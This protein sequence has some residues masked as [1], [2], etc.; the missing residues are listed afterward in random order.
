MNTQDTTLQP[1]DKQGTASKLVAASSVKANLRGALDE[2]TFVTKISYNPKGQR[3][4]IRYGNGATTK[5]EYDE[6]RSD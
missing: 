1:K 2:T 5:Y 6:K 4:R 3:E